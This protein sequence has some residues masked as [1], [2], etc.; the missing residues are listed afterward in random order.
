MVPSPLNPKRLKQLDAHFRAANYLSA[1]QI[2]LRSNVLLTEPLKADDI[3]ARLLGHWG[4][5]PGLNLIYTHL[6]RLIQDT[7]TKVLYITGP[8]H[9]GPAL[10]ANVFLEGVMGEIYPDLTRDVRGM[11][12]LMREFSWPGG[13]PSHVSPPTPGSIHEGGE[14]G[15]SLLHAFGAA[16]DNPDLLVACVVGDGEAET[17]PLAASWQS[18]KFLNPVTD[19]AVLPILHLNGYK[20]SGPTL[21]GR[22]SDEEIK[23]YFEGLH[24]HPY[25]VEG[26]DPMSVHK[27]MW[28]TLDQCYEEIQKLKGKKPHIAKWPMI[29]LRTPKGW[30][31]P[32]VVDGKAIEGTFRSH[33]VPLGDVTTNPDHL[34]VVEEWFRSYK[35]DE[36]FDEMG[37]PCE[38]VLSVIPKKELRMGA[39]PVANGGLILKELSLPAIDEYAISIETPGATIGE[40]TRQMGKWVSQIMVSNPNNFLLFCPDETNSNRFGNAFDITTRRYLGKTLESD[41]SLGADGRVFEVLSEHLCQGWLEGYLLT[42][43][44]GLFPCYEAFALIIDSML[45]QHAKWLKA[46]KELPWRKPI[47]SLNYVL[48]SHAW[49]QDHNGYSHQGPGFIESVLQKKGSVARIYLPV[50]ANTLLAV[51]EHCFQ[52]KDMINLIVAG[53]QPMPQ[54]LSLKEARAH[55]AQGIGIWDFAST[56]GEPDLI[57]ACAGDT[58]TLETLAATW[59]IR[60]EFPDLNVRVINVIDLFT[61]ETHDIHS[62]GLDKEDYEALFGSDIPVI[63]AFHGHPRVI[64]E[65]TYKRAN[66]HHFHV[67]GYIEEGTTT[68]PF[69]MVVCNRMSRYHLAINALHRCP[70]VKSFAGDTIAKFQ[71]TLVRHKAYIQKHGVDL[72][73]VTTWH[74]SA[75]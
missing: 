25:F 22:M 36:L 30:T 45:N 42:G 57:M 9:G 33:Q 6:N 17:G 58:P 56:K 18:S 5:S 73:E 4:S 2:Y 7:E 50:D 67:H 66:N 70:K 13:V 34:K 44:H 16:Y 59:L 72:P 65:L 64:H 61:L 63:F 48:T 40:A 62:H 8:G 32:K 35:I 60:K 3:K 71:E 12:V 14:L 28:R 49:R 74:W 38:D 31:G 27:Q 54:W 68:T 11:E 41:E 51:A 47:S 69:D 75:P 20:I 24:Y 19:G 43:R 37:H 53:K 1:G 26:N 39:L 29:V 21:F 55:C 52:T 10:R 46:C 23:R 15:Y